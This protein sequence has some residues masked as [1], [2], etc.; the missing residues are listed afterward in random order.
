MFVGYEFRY[1]LFYMIYVLFSD[2]VRWS[3]DWVNVEIVIVCWCIFFFCFVNVR[4]YF[5]I[6]VDGYFE[7]VFRKY[8]VFG[9]V[10]EGFNILKK[11][12]VVFIFGLLRN[13]FNVFVKILDCGEVILGKEN[14]VGFVKD[15]KF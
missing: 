10:V 6:Y 12:E 2:G 1:C 15:G 14:G 13:K 8:V 5:V 9:K 11:I 4:K 7:I 3:Y